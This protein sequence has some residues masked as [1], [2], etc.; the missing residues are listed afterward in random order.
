MLK[1]RLI[2]LLCACLLPAAACRA[3]QDTTPPAPGVISMDQRLA[4]DIGGIRQLVKISTDDARKPALLLLSGGP[5]SS[6]INNEERFTSLLRQRFTVVQWDQRGAGQTLEMNPGPLRPTLAQME[7]D[8]YQVVNYVRREL[9]QEK[10]YL[11]GSSWGNVLGFDIVRKHPQL[12]H[13]YFAVNPVISQLRSEQQLLAVLQAHFKDNALAMEELG[14]VRIPFTQD[15]DLFYLRKWL[16][17]KE[18]KSAA[19]TSAFRDG[20]LDW[21]RTWSPVWNEVM[22]ID[23]PTTLK[24]VRCP[25][26]FFVGKQDIQTA[27]AITTAYAQQLDAPDKAVIVFEKS[28]HQIHRDE[29]ELFQQA[30]IKRLDAMPAAK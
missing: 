13:A 6:M 10:I 14:K 28:G 11:L 18:G 22:G 1:T 23:L 5:G 12:L 19:A 20:F 17:I 15:E 16:F 3:Q 4:V 8:T 27:T 7:E 21:S 30:I 24:Q 9:K 2:A 26:Y 29:P 25:V